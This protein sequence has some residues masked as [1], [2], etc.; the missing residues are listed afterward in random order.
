[1]SEEWRRRLSLLWEGGSP[2]SKG[3]HSNRM[4]RHPCA[5]HQFFVLAPHLH[6]PFLLWSHVIGGAS[7]PK[8]RAGREE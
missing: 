3:T 6:S 5:V 7:S 8:R 2:A 4:H 1:M